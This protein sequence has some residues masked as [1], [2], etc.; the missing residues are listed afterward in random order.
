[1]LEKS[2][3]KGDFTM[4][5]VDSITGELN[6]YCHEK[7][8][9]T[10]N[11]DQAYAERAV[12]IAGAAKTLTAITNAAT[13]VCTTA[14]AHGFSVGDV[15]TIAGV[16]PAG[17]NGRWAITAI[18]SATTFSIYVGTA[19]GA[20]TV[21]G[22][23]TALSF[24][25]PVGMKLGTGSTAASKT[26]AGAALVTYLS[27]SAIA[28]DATYPQSSI[29]ASSRRIKYQCTYNAGVA[30]SA[31]PITEAVIYNDYTADA[32][33]SAANTYA[34]AIVSGGTKGASDII[35]IVWNHDFLGA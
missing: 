9:I 8:L 23:A 3:I 15:V 16:T 17:Y 4:W 10:Q 19:L 32:T 34:R 30:T 22:T 27:T 1:M 11:G 12:Q 33:S 28:F 31:S 35:I 20:G 29:P 7:N 25:A 21:F 18:G 13:A 5:C 24:A 2:G 26:G 14:T 6:W